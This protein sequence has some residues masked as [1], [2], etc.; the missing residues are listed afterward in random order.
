MIKSTIFCDCTNERLS[1]DKNCKTKI[2]KICD[3][4]LLKPLILLLHNSMTSFCYSDIQKRSKII[5]V[6]KNCDKTLVKNYRPICLLPM[7]GKIFEK[8][9]FNRLYNLLLNKRLLNPNQPGFRLADSR[10]NQSLAI[11]NEI[12]EVFDCNPSLEL[13]SI[14]LDTCHS[15]LASRFLI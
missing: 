3:K 1:E 12:F 9:I 8:I 14:F 5:P 10:V 4:S 2:K 7:F 6:H 13:T 11:I 15:L